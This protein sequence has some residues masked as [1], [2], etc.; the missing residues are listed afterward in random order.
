MP[1]TVTEADTWEDELILPLYNE[2]RLWVSGIAPLRTFFNKLINRTRYLKSI[3]VPGVAGT[4]RYIIPGYMFNPVAATSDII[5]PVWTNNAGPVGNHD[6]ADTTDRVVVAPLLLPFQKFMI[7]RFACVASIANSSGTAV[8]RLLSATDSVNTTT[9]A[10][11]PPS[12]FYDATPGSISV[13]TLTEATS[14]HF[15]YELSQESHGAW[16]EV[17]LNNGGTSGGVTLVKVIV[18]G[19]PTLL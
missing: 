10:L 1:E 5:M 17:W 19:Y 13:V 8:Y 18:E 9:S 6:M 14:G 7:T 12:G 15:P 16:I 3:L 11:K 2:P 4:R